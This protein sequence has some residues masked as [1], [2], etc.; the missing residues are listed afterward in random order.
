MTMM[1][2]CQMKGHPILMICCGSVW[3]AIDQNQFFSYLA[4]K[5]WQT[6]AVDLLFFCKNV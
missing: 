2:G 3:Q 4:D 1:G 5:L 6:A